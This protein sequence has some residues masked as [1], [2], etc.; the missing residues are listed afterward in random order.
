MSFQFCFPSVP[1]ILWSSSLG[2]GLAMSHG[3]QWCPQLG[4]SLSCF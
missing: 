2:A 3:A 1:A 4:F